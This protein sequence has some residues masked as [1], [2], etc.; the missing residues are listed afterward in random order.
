MIKISVFNITLHFK[1]KSIVNLASMKF[2]KATA[3]AQLYFTLWAPPT[4]SANLMA[5]LFR[6]FYQHFYPLNANDYST[7]NLIALSV[8]HYL[9][10]PYGYHIFVLDFCRS[11]KG[12]VHVFYCLMICS[13]PPPPPLVSFAGFSLEKALLYA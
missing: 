9:Y 11:I 6:L 3:R 7:Y 10:N 4:W 5:F 8:H 12:S 1:P 13:L 2:V